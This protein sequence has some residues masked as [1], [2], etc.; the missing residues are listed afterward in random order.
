MSISTAMTF[1]STVFSY[2]SPTK[3]PFYSV[4]AFGTVAIVLTEPIQK[5]WWL[6]VLPLAVLL[7]FA[8]ILSFKDRPEFDVKEY[9][10]QIKFS[11]AFGLSTAVL[12]FVFVAREIAPS[13]EN[14]DN[15]WLFW[16]GYATALYQIVVFLFYTYVYAN[17][18]SKPL[19]KNFIQLALITSTYLIG[20]TYCAIQSY[21]QG[22]DGLHYI[23]ILSVLYVLWAA[24]MTIW[25]IHL[26]KTIKIVTPED[27]EQVPAPAPLPKKKKA[28]G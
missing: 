19:N 20:S 3:S 18:E 21:K 8:T 2:F 24:T 27:A 26:G 15:S 17:T 1:A 13:S 23:V 10:D 12:C 5:N 22:G 4:I 6:T 9:N 25:T 14:G 7:V 28:A 16:V 11:R